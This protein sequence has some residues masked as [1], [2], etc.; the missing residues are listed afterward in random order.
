MKLTSKTHSRKINIASISCAFLTKSEASKSKQ[1]TQLIKDH[2]KYNWFETISSVTQNSNIYNL[3]TQQKSLR[4]GNDRKTICLTYALNYSDKAFWT[5]FFAEKR[6]P[7][8]RLLMHQSF[9][10]PLLVS[11]ARHLHFMQVK[12]MDA[13]ELSP[14]TK[15]EW[16]TP[17]PLYVSYTW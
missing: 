13:G 6:T 7:D 12:V 10:I 8:R 5:F 2:L 9:K 15:S 11:L 14:R 3:M 1:Q 16:W 17:P 4:A